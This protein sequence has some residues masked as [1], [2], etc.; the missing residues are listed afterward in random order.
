MQ[1]N[2]TSEVHNLKRNVRFDTALNLPAALHAST[3]FFKE[4]D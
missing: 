4:G 2:L 3:L 1:P